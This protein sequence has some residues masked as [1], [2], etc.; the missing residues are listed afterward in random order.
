[1]A[2]PCFLQVSSLGFVEHLF[3][4]QPLPSE[5][6]NRALLRMLYGLRFKSV[7]L[8]RAGSIYFRRVEVWSSAYG[9]ILASFHHDHGH[10]ALSGYRVYIDIA[11]FV[12]TVSIR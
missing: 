9:D 1:M 8:V 12:S 3:L 6:M 11:C 2:C 4:E 7:R 10:G 5:R